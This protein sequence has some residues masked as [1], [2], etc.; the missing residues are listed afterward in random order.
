MIYHFIYV[1]T[2]AVRGTV[3]LNHPDSK[4]LSFLY[5]TVLTDGQ[6]KFDVD[7]PTNNTCVFADREVRGSKPD[8]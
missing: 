4:D 5:G 8:A 7:I 3:Q 2:E 1:L 6:D